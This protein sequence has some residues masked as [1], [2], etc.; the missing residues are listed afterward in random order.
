MNAVMK[1]VRIVPGAE[2][3]RLEI[4]E[5]PTP[6]PGPDQ[7]LVRVVASGLNR[8][9]INIVKRARGDTPLPLGVEFAG[10]VADVGAG[11]TSWKE[12]DRVVGHGNGGQ[13]EYVLAASRALMGIPPSMTWLEAA[14]FPNVFITAHDA[15]MTN[16]E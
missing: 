4:R 15:L 9:E 5:V 13:A 7:V 2:G 11:V 8:G 3:G 6:Q 16:G 10:I 12:G 14:A 1:T